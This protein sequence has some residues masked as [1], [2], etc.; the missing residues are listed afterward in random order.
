MKL[1]K[2]FEFGEFATQRC[3]LE[4]LFEYED[5]ATKCCLSALSKSAGFPAVLLSGFVN[6]FLPGL[7]VWWCQNGGD[8][9]ELDQ[10]W[11]DLLEVAFDRRVVRY[12]LQN[13]RTYRDMLAEKQKLEGAYPVLDR[14]LDEENAVSLTE[15]EHRG[16]RQYLQVR[17][18][19]EALEREYYYFLGQ[20]DMRAMD[21]VMNGLSRESTVPDEDSR[22]DRFLEHVVSGRMDDADRDF[23]ENEEFAQRRREADEAGRKIDQIELPREKKALIDAY[24]SAVEAEW[25][26]YGELAYRYG[27]EDTL[28]FLKQ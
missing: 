6:S 1:W 25:L 11:T 4:L 2:V 19:M 8:S 22:R 20:A 13:S 28:A 24:V 12:L 3:V 21:R 16:L 10:L 18:D 15:E 27:V 5:S 17:A 23:M 26:C 9:M 14:L 7:G